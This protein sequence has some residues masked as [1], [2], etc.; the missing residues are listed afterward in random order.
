[1]SLEMARLRLDNV[2]QRMWKFIDENLQVWATEEIVAKIKTDARALGLSNRVIDAI[3]FEMTGFMKGELVFDLEIDGVPVD[4]FLENGTRP[5]IIEPKGKDAGGAN[6]LRW[7]SES[8]NPIFRKRV[9]HPGFSGYHFM[10]DGEQRYS[11]D[12][13]RR[14]E[15]E[16]EN[17]AQ[18]ERLR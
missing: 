7:L 2:S 13:Q 16:S 9:Q 5:H 18:V 3:S 10:R 6:V 4:E 12:L 8:G 14:I 17:F 15:E 1:M 11:Q